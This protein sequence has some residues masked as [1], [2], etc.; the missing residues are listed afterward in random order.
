MERI[1]IL[2]GI[3]IGFYQGVARPLRYSQGFE[4]LNLKGIETG[5]GVIGGLIFSIK[6]KIDPS[7]CGLYPAP[8]PGYTY[9]DIDG[10]PPEGRP[11]EPKLPLKSFVI[12]LPLGSEVKGIRVEDIQYLE[13][14]EVLKIIPN[15]TPLVRGDNRGGEYIPDKRIYNSSRYF[16]GRLVDFYTGSSK[17]STYLFLK[18]SP[19]QYI[20]AKGKALLI[21]DAT[22]KVYY[23]INYQQ[24]HCQGPEFKGIIISPEKFLGVAESLK[25]FHTTELGIPTQIIATGWIESVYGEAPKPPYPGYSQREP[26]GIEGYDFSLARK[27]ISYLRDTPSHPNLEYITILGDAEEVPPS[28]YY[29]MDTLFTDVEWWAPSDFLYASPDYDFVPNYKVGRISVSDISEAMGVIRKLREWY[30]ASWQWFSNTIVAG[31]DPFPYSFPYYDEALLADCINREYLSGHTL[32]KYLFSDDRFSSS[33]LTPYLSEGNVGIFFETGHG[34]GSAIWFDDETG[35]E[36]ESLLN[37]EKAEN[38]PLVI[39]PACIVGAFDTRLAPDLKFSISFGEAVLKSK[40]GGIC[41]FGGTRA[42]LAGFDYYFDE[43]RLVITDHDYFDRIFTNTIRSYHNG[44][45]DLGDIYRESIFEFV[46][47]EDMRDLYNQWS[48]FCFTLLGDPALKIPPQITGKNYTTPE[49]FVENPTYINVKNCPVFHL[50]EGEGIVI[51]TTTNSP[52]LKYKLCKGILGMP[53]LDKREGGESYYFKPFSDYQLYIVRAESEDGKEGWFYTY[54]T[55]S[56]IAVDGDKK[57]WERA[58]LKPIAYDPPDFTTED[59][60]IKNL[61]LTNDENRWYF[62]FDALT[63]TFWTTYLLAIDYKEGGYQGKEGETQDAFNTWVA[64]GKS[65]PIDCE[66]GLSIYL[67]DNRAYGWL[68]PW[69]EANEKW[70]SWDKWIFFPDSGCILAYDSTT[71]FIE[72]GIP[73][74]IFNNSN[75]LNISLFSAGYDT[76]SR[77]YSPALDA[78]PTDPATYTSPCF[79]KEYANTIT[80]FAK[81]EFD[82]VRAGISSEPPLSKFRLTTHPNPLTGFASITFELPERT[83]ISLKVYDITGRLRK[84]LISEERGAG[85]YA[86]RWDATSLPPGIYFY[87]LESKKGSITKKVILVR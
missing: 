40:A 22:I 12:A 20:P 44:A 28:Y 64:F 66:I 58:G 8:L 15:P 61:Y 80:Q 13:I 63:H 34:S 41:F 30:P 67:N 52:S 76:L 62:G 72:L 11:G 83:W 38:L 31:G 19:V 4:P 39:T 55:T 18:F 56:K 42:N 75:I 85:V 82:S 47:S 6:Y 29:A 87:R 17:D 36:A 84:T 16:P 14:E 79:G 70:A 78:A 86:L 59:Y 73:T 33:F 74:E 26:E 51:K 69:D 46:S 57:D 60:E 10:L 48:I 68:I 54:A 3:I 32:N 7:N 21:T 77:E 53:A 45:E 50:R 49:L 25:E 1:F 23:N 81:V 37:Y 24:V 71:K 9:L 65:H 2:L 5:S 27:I 35:I 43:G